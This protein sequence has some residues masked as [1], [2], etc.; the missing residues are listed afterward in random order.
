MSNLHSDLPTLDD[1]LERKEMVRRIATLIS[2]CKPPHVFGVL[3]EWGSGKT[4][5]LAQLWWYLTDEKPSQVGTT[6]AASP[7]SVWDDWEKPAHVT[8]VWFESWRYQHEQLPIVALLN[9]IRQQLSWK[10]KAVKWGQKGAE[11][12]FRG[13]LLSLEDLT[14]RIGFQASKIQS[15]GERWEQDHYAYS[16]PTQAIREHLEEA[17]KQLLG[18]PQEG[19]SAPRLVVI[20]DD[21]DRCE[22]DAA[23]RLMEGIKIYLN[24]SNCVF[25]LGMNQRIV[26]RAIAQNISKQSVET[27]ESRRRAREYLEKLC[28]DIWHLPLMREPE[29]LL[30]TLLMRMPETADITGQTRI[31]IRRVCKKTGCLPPNAR[32]VKALANVLY[33]FLDHA[34]VTN[35]LTGEGGSDREVGLILLMACLYQYHPELYRRIEWD[36]RFFQT[37]CQWATGDPVEHTILGAVTRPEEPVAPPEGALTAKPELR[38]SHPDPEQGNVLRVQSLIRELDPVTKDEIQSLL[39]R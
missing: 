28:Q 37:L 17:L 31:A 22:A 23:Y 4:S 11:V 7:Q 32:R 19:R 35:A 39:L 21:L 10:A 9:E 8:V 20:V 16:L 38:L 24:L 33:R 26:E 18:E 14:K 2:N 36:S 29:A 27:D 1:C 3:G 5:V 34:R 12:A 25:V 30:D 13:A 15:T 6:V